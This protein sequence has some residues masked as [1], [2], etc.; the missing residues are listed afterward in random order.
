MVP[1]NAELSVRVERQRSV[2]KVLGSAPGISVHVTFSGGADGTWFELDAQ[3]ERRRFSRE[4]VASHVALAA[5]VRL[6]GD[7]IDFNK[8]PSEALLALLLRSL[9]VYAGRIDR[10]VP[11]PKWGRPIR[12]RP[13]ERALELLNADLS[14]F[15][16]VELLARAVG[17]SRPVFAREFVRVLGLSPMRYLTQQ[18]MERAARLL[19]ETDAGLA[20]IAG[21]VGYQSEFAFGR[22]F[23]RHHQVPPGVFRRHQTVA[24]GWTALAA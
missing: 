8:A 22:A 3:G 6:I 18:R 24:A 1:V 10:A 15:W 20:E 23:R 17:L 16:T 7:E 14:K 21:H 19:L 11:R 13:V 2:F 5:V 9:L 12:N 4:V